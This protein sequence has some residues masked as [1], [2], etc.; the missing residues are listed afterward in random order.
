[1]RCV[2]HTGYF[3]HGNGKSET[4]GRI[5]YMNNSTIAKNLEARNVDMCGKNKGRKTSTLSTIEWTK[6]T[7]LTP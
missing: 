3:E 1:M 7:K 5:N 2:S 4:R 6:I